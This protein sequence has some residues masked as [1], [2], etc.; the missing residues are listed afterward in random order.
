MI[1]AAIVLLSL[2]VSLPVSAQVAADA[3]S[4]TIQVQ[5]TGEEPRRT[6]RYAL[7]Q[8][9]PQSVHMDMNI[10][11]TIGMMGQEMAQD[12][13][14]IRSTLAISEVTQNAD[15]SA[16]LA[17]SSG[18]MT[19]LDDGAVDPAM[20]AALESGLSAAPETN[21]TLTVN[22]RGA[23]VS[24]DIDWTG[25]P[26]AVRQQVHSTMQS[27]Q[28][29]VVAFPEEAVGVGATWSVP[30]SVDANGITL[31][32]VA[33]YTVTSMSESSV[34]VSSVL[35]QNASSQTMAVPGMPANVTAN[36][37]SF[38]GS[39]TGAMTIALNRPMPTGTLDMQAAIG[40]S[41]QENP[42]APAMDMQ[43]NMT[44]AM[45]LSDAP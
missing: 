11:M 3:G 14:T 28:Q 23:L 13:P 6:L 21:G 44:M 43:M 7:D 40:M 41:I 5:S 26:E 22:E 29:S 30:M 20:R 9:A 36:L 10:D 19:V 38:A 18:A 37:T 42:S 16:T 45:Q 31:D 39:G 4:A 12:M 27:M 32:Q 8:F 1:R 25:V 17:F 2:L 24:F 34:T 33:T 35:T 15:G